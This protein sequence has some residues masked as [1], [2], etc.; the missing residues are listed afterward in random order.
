MMKKIEMNVVIKGDF[1]HCCPHGYTC[2]VEKNKCEKGIS[3]P[4]FTKKAAIPLDLP[5]KLILSHS[6][7]SF[8]IVQCPGLIFSF[9]FERKFIC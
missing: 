2:D 4:W 3:I 6:S 1:S 5:S 7:S 8:S 9:S